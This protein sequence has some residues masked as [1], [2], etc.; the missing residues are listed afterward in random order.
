MATLTKQCTKMRD[1]IAEALESKDKH[2]PTPWVS[3]EGREYWGTDKG[4]YVIA[5]K[6]QGTPKIAITKGTTA[7]ANA[8]HIVKCVN[9]HDE[10]MGF[11]REFKDTGC[12]ADFLNKLAEQLIEKYGEI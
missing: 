3:E 8:E 11:V 7:K 6:Q 5:S 10:L 4:L 12:D 9:A 2:T 1:V